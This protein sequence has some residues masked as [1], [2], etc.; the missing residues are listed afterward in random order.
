VL[1]LARELLALSRAGLRRRARLDG[2]GRDEAVFL[3]PLDQLVEAGETQADRLLARY[4]GAW[5]GSVE[6]VFDALAY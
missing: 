1:E 6:P 5:N 4:H 2:F 3:D